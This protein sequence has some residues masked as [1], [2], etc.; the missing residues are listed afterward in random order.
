MNINL[1][2]GAVDGPSWAH[3]VTSCQFDLLLLID[4]GRISHG[5][6]ATYDIQVKMIT[7]RHTKHA[8]VL[9]HSSGEGATYDRSPL[10]STQFFTSLN[11]INQLFHKIRFYPFSRDEIATFFGCYGEV[12][13]EM[14][15][16]EKLT[17]ALC[18][19]I[20]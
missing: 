8:I 3:P 15:F 7:L 1:I 2:I 20:V 18:Y 4:L 11:E 9:A 17:T 19:C 13:F 16:V 14:E 10:Q 12:P 6:Q 5:V